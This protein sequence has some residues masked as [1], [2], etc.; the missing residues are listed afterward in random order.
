[1]NK[2]ADTEHDLNT[3]IKNRWSPRAFDP[4]A[5]VTKAELEAL[6]EAARWAPS[7][8]NSQPWRYL[9]GIRGD[10]TFGKILEN[11]KPNNARWA[12]RASA[13]AVAVARTKKPDG[14]VEKTGQYDTGQA[15][16]Y[17]SLQAQ[18]RGLSVRQMAGF[19][20]SIAEAL[21]IPA[22][23]TPMAVI[24]IGGRGDA[25]LLGDET[26]HAQEVSIRTRRPLAGIAHNGEWSA[27]FEV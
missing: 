13:L 16:A 24:A 22:D 11:L 3:L 25:A 5:K 4:A 20:P 21:A 15:S 2:S 17:F 14:T 6:F 18:H 8:N 12:F 1:M 23:Y 10:A 19:Q 26:L 27:D 9:Y 7:S